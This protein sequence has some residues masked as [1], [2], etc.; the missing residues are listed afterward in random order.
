[1][2]AYALSVN[3]RRLVWRRASIRRSLSPEASSSPGWMPTISAFRSDCPGKLL[4]C[5]RTRSSIW[6]AAAP[7]FSRADGEL[8]GEM[9]MGLDHRD[10]VARPFVGFPFPHPTWCGRASWFRNNPYDSEL[11]YAEDQDSVVAQLSPQ[12]TGGAGHRPSGLSPGSAGTEEAPSGT[13]DFHE[14]GLA[15]RCGHRRSSAGIGRDRKSYWE[16][17]G[18]CRDPRIGVE[19][20]DAVAAPEGRF[21]CG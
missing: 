9:P 5:V 3:L 20:A 10:I 17:C 7:W 21:S 19:S 16:R 12:Q 8:I 11:R 14:V 13:Y 6:S 15:Q 4:A 1:M 18:R 2:N